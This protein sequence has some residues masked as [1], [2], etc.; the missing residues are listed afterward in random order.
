MSRA[1]AL[2]ATL[3]LATAPGCAASRAQA[4]AQPQW[5]PPAQDAAYKTPEEAQAAFLTVGKLAGGAKFRYAG[6]GHWQIMNGRDVVREVVIGGQADID[7][8]E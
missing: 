4:R 3:V 7:W 2:L 8:N 1:L 6:N 5:T